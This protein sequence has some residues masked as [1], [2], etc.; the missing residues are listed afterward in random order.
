M[1][2]G[3]SDRKLVI[4][5]DARNNQYSVSA[6][7]LVPEEADRLIQEWNQHLVE[8]CRLL[9]LNQRKQHKTTNPEDCRACREAVV[10]SSGLDPKPTFTRRKP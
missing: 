2:N 5:Y 4:L 6:H 1:T 7:N 3:K 9:A 8:G 10:R